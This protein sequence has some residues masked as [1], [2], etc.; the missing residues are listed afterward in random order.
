MQEALCTLVC[1][2]RSVELTCLASQG[3]R[4][5]WR[6]VGWGG[7]LGNLKER[8]PHPHQRCKGACL[9]IG[10]IVC[11]EILGGRQLAPWDGV[12]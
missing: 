9:L 4:C 11:G 7:G 6:E 5:V 3:F 2:L 1:S 10:G 12:I 8:V